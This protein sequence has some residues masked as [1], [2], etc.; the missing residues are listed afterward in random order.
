MQRVLKNGKR[1]L[2][3]AIG[4][5]L[6]LTSTSPGTATT[7]RLLYAGADICAA[8]LLPEDRVVTAAHCL[9]HPRTGRRLDL[10]RLAFRPNGR[11][12]PTLVLAAALP[13]GVG[14]GERIMRRATIASDVA[15][16]TLTPLRGF[17]PVALEPTSG[18][19][20]P[21]GSV[22]RVDG[23][24]GLPD[25]HHCRVARDYGDVIA[26]DCVLRPGMSGAGVFLRVGDD[27]RLIAVVS[28]AFAD[29]P[30]TI[31]VPVTELRRPTVD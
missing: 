17:D 14:R 19:P 4:C 10:H 27:W 5:M 6:W 7:G 3:A 18:A 8:T 11:T 31:L 12:E 1:A 28:A 29:R 24:S 26:I 25:R 30:Q 20:V 9:M 16:L 2:I 21:R 15:Y 13:R 22:V 23:G